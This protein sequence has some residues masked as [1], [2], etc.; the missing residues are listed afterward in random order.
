VALALLLLPILA[1]VIAVLWVLVK[2]DGGPGFFSH[3]RVGRDGRRFRC[4]KLRTMVP[5]AEAVLKVHLAENPEAAAEWQRD[6][7]LRQ[8]PRITRIGKFLRRT[9]LDELPQIWNV[10]MREMSLV[11][12]R[13][14]TAAEVSKYGPHF[15]KCFAVRPGITGLWQTR[16]RNE[17]TYKARV[18]Y[19]SLYA[20]NASLLLDLAII[21]MTAAS[22]LRMTGR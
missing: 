2:L 9:S 4:W 13:P 8:D 21:V 20:Q 1:P 18:Q 15:D 16:G 6:Y 17:T 10:L 5:D 3:V 14:I 22:V 19:D 11:G 12:P 7:K